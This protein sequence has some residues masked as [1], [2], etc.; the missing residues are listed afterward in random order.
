VV[1]APLTLYAGQVNVIRKHPAV[2]ELDGAE[3]GKFVWC[4]QRHERAFA[5]SVYSH[6]RN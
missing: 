4:G 6:A 1:G 2:A 3:T 5:L